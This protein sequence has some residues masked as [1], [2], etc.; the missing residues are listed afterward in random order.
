MEANIDQPLMPLCTLEA[1][2][3]T[4]ISNIQRRLETE[5]LLLIEQRWPTKSVIL[6]M[7]Q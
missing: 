5:P 7:K 1:A 2:G 3:Y 6:E 4:E